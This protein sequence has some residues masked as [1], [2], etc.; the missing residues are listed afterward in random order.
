MGTD[1]M[2]RNFPCLCGKGDM[3]AEWSEHDTWPSPN[4]SIAWSF[5]CAD[6]DAQYEFYGEYIIKKTDAAKVRALTAEVL[7]ANNN[8]CKAA[9]AKYEKRWV[10]LVAAQPTKK[11]QHRLLRYFSY[12]TFLKD[13]SRPGFIEQQ[14][15]MHFQVAPKDCLDHLGIVD[16]EIDGL[17]GIAKAAAE[18][19]QNFWN[20]IEKRTVPYR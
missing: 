5:E 3:L 15:K 7:A 6:C 8:L 4:R 13:A 17:E 9:T 2:E 14:S 19:G 20:S 10:E 18:V 11:A 16:A 12:G 1:R